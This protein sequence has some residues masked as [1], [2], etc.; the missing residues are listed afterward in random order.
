MCALLLRQLPTV[1]TSQAGS[2]PASQPASQSVSQPAGRPAQVESWHPASASDQMTRMRETPPSA[3]C[4]LAHCTLTRWVRSLPSQKSGKQVKILLVPSRVRQRERPNT[5]KRKVWQIY[6]S[7]PGRS[8]NVALT[9]EQSVAA[10]VSSQLLIWHFRQME[11]RI[12]RQIFPKNRK[13]I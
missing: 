2:Q 11:V 6:P 5:R 4:T 8:L 3:H 13:K 9:K 12:D 7:A 1:E 10:S